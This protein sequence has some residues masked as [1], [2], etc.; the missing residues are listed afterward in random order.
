MSKKP[1]YEN[2]EIYAPNGLFLGYIPTHRF[3]WYIERDLAEKIND[4][5]IKLSF[6]PK[7]IK[8]LEAL[9]SIHAPKENKCVV[10]GNTEEINRY[11]VTPYEIKKLLPEKYKAHRANDVVALCNEDVPDADYFTR[12]FKF[13]LFKKYDID[14]TNFKL[15]GKDDNIYKLVKKILFRKKK[16]YYKD[17][18]ETFKHS[19]EY[20]N[21]CLVKY[22]NKIPTKEELEHFI[23][24]CEE[25][26]QFEGFKTP[27]NMLVKK[28]IDENNIIGFLNLWKQ[29]FVD[30]LEPKYL[31]WD[32]WIESNDL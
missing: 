20:A 14:V 18:D 15:T 13:E 23:V 21:E 19:V 28:V 6:E 16:T 30:K 10:C 26:M 2:M 5:A 27:E 24:E 7:N 11:R 29:N 12:E 32:F 4:K 25:K 17:E 8:S 22:F 31:P 9:R 3:K 1:I